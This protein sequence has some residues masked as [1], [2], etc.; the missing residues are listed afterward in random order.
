M[1]NEKP[2]VEFWETRMERF[3]EMTE[4]R[5]DDNLLTA[6]RSGDRRAFESLYAQ[7]QKRVFSVALNFFGGD[8]GL[9]QD[10]TQQ[11]F[12]KMYARIGDF[13]GDAEFTTW[14]Y[15]MTVNACIDEQ[16][17]RRR[18]FLLLDF[19][20]MEDKGTKKNQDQ[21]VHRREIADEVQKA[22]ATLKPKF[23]LPILLK[24]VEELSYQEI[25]E[26]LECSC[27]T[28]ASRLNRGHKMLASKL[29]HLKS[30]I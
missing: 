8:H 23:R 14:L 16:R 20:G 18:F 9:A 30:E 3:A 22:I 21:R 28:V 27:G 26:I 19:F 6:C 13:R 2:G 7:N 29:G 17:R 24:Y 4:S 25:A 15:R 12:L 11:V 5:T 10:V 1:Q